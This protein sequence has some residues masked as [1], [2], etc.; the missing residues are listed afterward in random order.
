MFFVSLPPENQG[1]A[2]RLYRQMTPGYILRTRAAQLKRSRRHA[3]ARAR[4]VVHI[5]WFSGFL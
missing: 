2:L 1:Q 5:H 4:R 3:E